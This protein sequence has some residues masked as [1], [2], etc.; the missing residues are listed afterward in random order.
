MLLVSL[1]GGIATGKSI[2]AQV[3]KQLGCY[4]HES[5]TLAH[6]LMLPMKP[7]WKSIVDHFGMDILNPDKT[8]NRSVLGNIVYSDSKEREYLNALLHPLVMKKKKEVIRRVENQGKHM[9]FISVAALTIEAGFTDYFDKIVIVYC[10][11]KTQLKRLRERDHIGYEEALKKFRSQMLPEEKLKYAD[12]IIDTS[13]TIQQTLER[14]EQVFRNL[15]VDYQLKT[16]S[17]T[18]F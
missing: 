11:K 4:I 18:N 5:D 7:A 14:S 15:M 1:T 13:G 12:Y 16:C 2:V 17:R 8:I 9:I 3:F 6:R 10:D